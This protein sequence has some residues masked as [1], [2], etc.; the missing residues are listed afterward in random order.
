MELFINLEDHN[1]RLVL[2]MRVIID[3]HVQVILHRA[4]AR[5]KQLRQVFDL[6]CFESNEL[7]RRNAALFGDLLLFLFDNEL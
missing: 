7:R 2:H 3:D 4:N 6:V 5:A 1:D